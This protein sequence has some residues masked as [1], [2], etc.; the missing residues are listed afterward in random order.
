MSEPVEI[1]FDTRPAELL[2]AMVAAGRAGMGRG[3]AV[4]VGALA[5][6]YGMLAAAGAGGLAVVAWRI[7]LDRGAALPLP[8][9]LMAIALV[10]ALGWAVFSLPW[11]ML[12]GRIA[13]SPRLAG[14][15]V[16]RAGP[17]GVE[18]AARDASFRVGWPLVDA[19]LLTRR[20]VAVLSGGVA[21]YVPRRALDDPDALLARLRAW[22]DAA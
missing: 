20:T 14:A 16:F 12:A 6:L 3:G 15:Q 19:V 18:I 11:R 21:L 10:L 8:A 7:W 2:D 17:D 13:G 5:T 4:A 1:R 22:K 9:L